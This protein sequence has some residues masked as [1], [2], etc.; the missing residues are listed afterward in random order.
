MM[1][2]NIQ[3][4]DRVSHGDGLLDDVLP[5]SGGQ[6]ENSFFGSLARS[7]SVIRQGMQCIASLAM[8]LVVS[9]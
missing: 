2:K 4:L 7:A 8:F 5:D 3:Q 9:A 1:T 6:G